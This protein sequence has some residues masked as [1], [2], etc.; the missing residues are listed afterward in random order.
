MFWKGTIC[1]ILRNTDAFY[2]I[3][4]SCICRNTLR[5]EA[6]ILR[7]AASFLTLFFLSRITHQKLSS[8]DAM[9]SRME[10][11]KTFVE[12]RDENIDIEPILFGLRSSLRR[13]VCLQIARQHGIIEMINENRFSNYVDKFYWRLFSSELR[14]VD[15]HIIFR[16]LCL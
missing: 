4:K 2:R 16:T 9:I 6:P 13:L 14:Q 11:Q 1:W 3:S 5:C 15:F 12:T 10:S 7:L 8:G